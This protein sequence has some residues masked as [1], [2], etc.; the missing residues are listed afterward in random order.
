MIGTNKNPLN[1]ATQ[2]SRI[3]SLSDHFENFKRTEGWKTTSSSGKGLALLINVSNCKIA[4]VEG[5]AP[6]TLVA[7][8][9][10]PSEFTISQ[11]QET[12][13]LAIKRVITPTKRSAKLK[14]HNKQPAKIVRMVIQTPKNI[15][16]GI[17]L[18]GTS[19]LEAITPLYAV[20]LSS[21]GSTEFNLAAHDINFQNHDGNSSLYAT[22]LGGN[23][24][25][26]LYG[27]NKI[28]TK[29]IVNTY[30]I[31]GISEGEVS[32]RGS[33]TSLSSQTVGSIVLSF[34]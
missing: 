28:T 11:N 9:G 8:D 14:P 27:H 25:A 6:H 20:M 18:T 2:H 5:K 22:M 19:L 12:N 29:G 30:T 10:D 3:Q 24:S 7:I 16:A 13:T 33:C 26:S 15:N 17:A 34:G 1:E 32:H 23:F 31:K 4:L 21:A